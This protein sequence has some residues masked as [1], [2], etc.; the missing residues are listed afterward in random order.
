MDPLVRAGALF[1][2]GKFPL[3]E[4]ARTGYNNLTAKI[5]FEMVI[6]TASQIYGKRITAVEKTR[7][8]RKLALLGVMSAFVFAGNYARIV[9]PIAIGGRTAFTLGNIL[10]CMSGLVLG[11]A[12]GLASALGSALYDLMNP[13][14]AAECWI[15][16][17]TKG[18]MGLVCGLTVR[19]ALQRGEL[20]FGRALLGTALGCLAYYILYFAKSIFCDGMLLSGLALPVAMAILPLKLPASLF[21]AGVALVGAPP[22]TLAV[23][24]GLK[25]ADLFRVDD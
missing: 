18:T 21:N 6:G 1:C 24:A 2:P 12:G 13:L 5:T 11:P 10:C 9:M 23:R 4:T 8:V 3:V 14:Y 22:L 17:F 19:G 7:S 15:T 25:R 16:F 20:G